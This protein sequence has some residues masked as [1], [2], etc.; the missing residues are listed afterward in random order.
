MSESILELKKILMDRKLNPY[1][2]FNGNTKEVMDFYSSVFGG[3]L[4]MNTFKQGG[5]PH[6]PSEENKIMHA[7][8]VADNGII[9][10]ADDTIKGR[11]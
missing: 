1:I 5:M 11:T 9:L 6:D 2:N 8:L 7:M 4:T 10:M 3:Q